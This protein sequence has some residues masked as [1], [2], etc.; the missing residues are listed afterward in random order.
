MLFVVGAWPLA[1]TE[2]P[3]YQDLP[4]HLAAV[5]VIENL[6]RY[7]EFVFNGFF[8]T[9]AALFAWLFV[10]GKVVGTKLAARLFALMVLGG[11]R[12]HPSALRPHADRQPQPDAH[13]EPVHVADGPQLVRLD[14]HARLRAV[15]PALARAPA[16]DRSPAARAV[17]R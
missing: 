5:T 17:A 10:V 3:P 12:V 4:N 8:K 1:L 16:R 2:V 14:G 13:R 6:E 9:N 7:P 15:R 11:Q